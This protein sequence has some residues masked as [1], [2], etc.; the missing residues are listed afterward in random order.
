MVYSLVLV[1]TLSWAYCS[2]SSFV[3]SCVSST[4]L[5]LISSFIVLDRSLL[6]QSLGEN[7]GAW[8]RGNLTLLFVY[9]EYGTTYRL[10]GLESF[11]Y[12]NYIWFYLNL[13]ALI[14]LISLRLVKLSFTNVLLES[15]LQN[16]LI[17]NS[18]SYFNS[19]WQL[20]LYAVF[21]L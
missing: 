11:F 7:T 9:M 15:S 4:E 20:S 3:R 21:L 12:F 16:V 1:S 17:L 19:S 2:Y 18:Y 6:K 10:E 13:S 8:R 5:Y 14:S